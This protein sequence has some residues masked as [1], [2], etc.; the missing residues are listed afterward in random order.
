M[1]KGQQFDLGFQDNGFSEDV[2]PV[3]DFVRTQF[4]SERK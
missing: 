4:T 1:F 3:N 2:C